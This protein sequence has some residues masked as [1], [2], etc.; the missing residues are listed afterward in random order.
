[1]PHR[2]RLWLLAVALA[3][4]GCTG[5]IGGP[6]LTASEV[7]SVTPAALD[8]GNQLLGQTTAPGRVT[9]ANGGTGVLAVTSV[10]VTGDY[11]QSNDCGTALD[12]GASCTV[13]LTFDATALGART[14]LLSV[15][16]S[17]G[18]SPQTVALSGAGV[19]TAPVAKVTPTTVDFGSQLVGPGTTPKVVTLSN[20]GNAPLSITN[21]SVTGPF[22]QTNT[23]GTSLAASGSCTFQVSFNPQSG[24][25]F[26]GLLSIADNAGGSPQTVALAGTGVPRVPVANVSP[27]SLAFGNQLVGQAT[28]AKPVTLNNSGGVALTVSIS[29]SGE[30]TQTNN[31]GTSLAAGASCTVQVT[32]SPTA[33]PGPQSGQL[34]F[35]DNAAGSPQTVALTG[36]GVANSPVVSLSPPSLPFGSQPVGQTTAAQGV[37]LTNTG[38]A[39]LN[40]SSIS[41]AGD[42][43]QTNTCGSTLAAGANCAVQV[44]FTPTL[45]GARNG[46]LSITDD[47]GG[48]PQTVPLS[49]T[50]TSTTV[51]PAYPLKV[52]ANGRY[53]VDQNGTPWRVQAEAAWAMTAVGTP[54]TVDTYLAT[55]KAQGFD[56]FYLMAMVHYGGPGPYYTVPNAPNDVNGNPPFATPN[57]FSTAG[58][59]T[60]SAAYWT[61][62]DTI[63]DKAAAQGMVVMLAYT[64]LGYGGG[65][66]GWAS[67]VQSNSTATCTA[68]GNW[69]GNRY[70][71]RP[72]IIWFALGD[73]TPPSG[74]TLEKNT[75]AIIQGI[76]AAGATQLFMAEVSPSGDSTPTLD[77]PFFASVL[78][79]NSFYGYGPTGHG[80]NFTQAARAYGV[81]P[82]KPA[83]VEEPGY[84]F[85]D[86][87]GVF[88]GD[89]YETRRSRFWSVLAGG[90]AGDGFGSRDVYVMQNFPACL[91]SAGALYSSYAFQLFGSFDWWN[92]LP[93]GVGPGLAGKT[94]I[95][96]G[97]GTGNAGDLSYVT[98]AV[99]ANGKHL[100]AYIPTFGG[101]SSVSITVDMTAMSGTTRAQWWDPST[102]S[103][104]AI[105]TGLANTG[106]HSFT[107]PG[108]NGS[109]Q[110]DWVLF[111]DVP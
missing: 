86:N 84:E 93:T 69:L 63:I 32:F 6:G 19:A 42:Y 65:A 39:L 92:L 7:A 23:C 50:G 80:D 3:A 74:S 46:T 48:S 54:A 12:A 31:C 52:S 95:T 77:A 43:A 72:N 88:T 106:T 89:S 87:T 98:S 101:T 99:T 53:L 37:T 62:V 34:S 58:T 59:T 30:F 100:L 104:T 78:D 13:E 35:T 96:A 11:A 18:N 9:L 68:W 8:F 107:S 41:V 66:Q 25:R 10:R 27:A 20:P 44:T 5:T 81:S 40:I 91:S 47:A 97:G 60:A 111:L 75:M 61:W 109:G 110:N 94:L 45:A 82:P 17:A 90:T 67:A 85:E 57:D 24:G 76:K 105:A 26:T 1:M 33:P 15:S 21:L 56:A 4:A 108:T 14:G 38:N 70:K 16:D 29:V 102:G 64:Y 49:G 28:T 22:T 83:W 55:R 36:T 73:Y 71:N 103:Y 79:M 2:N 51:G